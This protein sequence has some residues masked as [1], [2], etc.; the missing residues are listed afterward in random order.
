LLRQFCKCNTR[1]NA[2]GTGNTAFREQDE[3]LFEEFAEGLQS[4]QSAFRCDRLDPDSI[5]LP[6]MRSARAASRA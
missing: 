1:A 5:R 2:Q 3:E 4:L 6:A